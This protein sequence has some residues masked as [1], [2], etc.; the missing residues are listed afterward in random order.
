M[1]N[2]P[3]RYFIA[4][5]KPLQLGM[6]VLL[7]GNRF[8]GTWQ[9]Q[10]ANRDDKA[11]NIVQKMIERVN[12]VS[13]EC[14]PDVEIPS[15]TPDVKREDGTAV[16]VAM[17]PLAGLIPGN[18][19]FTAL[20]EVVSLY[21]DWIKRRI[22]EISLLD[23][24]YQ[25]A[26]SRHLD[27]CTRCAERMHEGLMYLQSNPKALK[28]F[29][30]ANHAIL[31]QQVRSGQEPR[32]TGYDAK[33]MRFT[34]SRGYANPDPLKSEEGRGKWRA[35]QIA[36]LLMSIQ[37]TVED[38]NIDRKT[39]ELIW[40]PTGGGKTEAYLGLA[41][42][43]MFMHRLQNKD[44]VGVQVLMRYT[45]RLLTAQQFQRASGLLC[46]MEYL[47]RKNPQELGTKE[48]SIGI[49]LGGSTTPNTR[50][51]AI[52]T[53]NGL[54]RGNSSTENKFILS[55]CPW[56][57]AQIG[58]ITY[59]KKPSK[60]EPRV[61]GYEQQGN[62]VVFKCPDSHCD[63]TNG[64]PIF[65]IDEDIYDKRPS[66]LI[67]TVD[68]FALLAWKPEVRKIFGVGEDGLRQYSPP[69]LIIQDELHL[70]SGP[71]GSMV[72][73][74]ETII[75]EL[76]TDRRYATPIPPKIVSSTATIRRYADQ[77]KKLYAR[78]KASLFPPPGLSA[79]NS[80][81]SRYATDSDGKLAHGRIYVGVHAPG[82][83]SLQTAQ[84]RSFTALLQA[85]LTLPIEQRDPWWT[86][87]LF[88]NSLRELGTTLSL[89]QSDI[90]D[91]FRVLMTRMGL[92]FS[93][94]RKVWN[95]L[96]LTGRL[97]NDEVP[98]AIA[99]LEVKY[100]QENQRDHPVDVCLASN[101][102][103]VGIDIDRL[104]LMAVVG[105]PKTTSQYI[106]VTGRVGRRWWERPGL[107][108]TLYGAS[109]P[110]DRSHFEKFRSYHE[111][112][113][114]QVEPTSVTPFSP[115]VLDRA[116]HAI[117]VSY[118]R[119]LGDR[120]ATLSPY[121]YPAKFIE[122]LRQIILTR[123]QAID[124]EE[125]GNFERVF[126]KRASEWLQW[127]R[128][129]WEDHSGENAALLRYAG[130][131]VSPS[132]ARLSWPTATSM[133]DVDAQC[134]ATITNLYA[135]EGAVGDDSLSH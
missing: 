37:S 10:L 128:N 78:D 36:F 9:G 19:G 7:I 94:I 58:P 63:F 54:R 82:L 34:F 105:Q 79:D 70:I 118:V 1:K 133:R 75:E 32:K 104:S 110:R 98:K 5:R 126:N 121:P 102:I 83:G 45:L 87:L 23:P 114:A 57:Q 2:S 3:W 60:L 123:V 119:Q 72:G 4:R 38:A 112:L 125:L 26:A 18:N 33:A 56:C 111:R 11:G 106:Q 108:V 88:F 113:Y 42:F 101:I 132:Q 90:P 44:D 51:D 116:L 122:Q 12:W 100:G 27:E 103:E 30:L 28:A 55:R 8:E 31:L 48:F 69:S 64:L 107:V 86:L 77:I 89:L 14:L 6:D 61:V 22:Q 85:S 59:A 80:F 129:L 117:I 97:R 120:D 52:N 73:L 95:V 53:L 47:R 124:E 21:E 93:Q 43:A 96:E 13:A 135:M 62:T 84:V 127:K 91:Y 76:C 115:P 130:A 29:Q 17:A 81:F 20:S 66:M 134:E 131:Y 46:A 24:K 35:F 49:W 40:F 92:D 50:Q 67:G 39:V 68:K 99:E 71:L 16:E 25:A 74:Y 65:V 109:K 15:I 41:A